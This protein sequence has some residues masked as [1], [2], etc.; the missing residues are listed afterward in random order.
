MSVFLS[1]ELIINFITD[2]KPQSL[3]YIYERAEGLNKFESDLNSHREIQLG[4]R[5]SWLHE[6]MEMKGKPTRVDNM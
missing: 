4:T 1:R 5:R 2:N 3:I 6:Y